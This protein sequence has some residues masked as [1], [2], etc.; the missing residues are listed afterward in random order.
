MGS[1]C[2][3]PGLMPHYCLI[4]LHEQSVSSISLPRKCYPPSAAFMERLCS[5]RRC[6]YTPFLPPQHRRCPPGL[7]TTSR[8]WSL[9]CL[10]DPPTDPLAVHPLPIHHI[11]FLPTRKPWSHCRCPLYGVQTTST[12]LG[13]K[14]LPNLEN[15]P[16]CS[17]ASYQYTTF[18]PCPSLP[19]PQAHHHCP[20]WLQVTSRRWGLEHLPPTHTRRD[21]LANTLLS[22][23]H[24]PFLPPHSPIHS[25][26][27]AA[28]SVGC[29][30]PRAAGGTE[31]S[32][33]RSGPTHVHMKIPHCRRNLSSVVFHPSL[34][35]AARSVGCRPP[36]GAGAWSAPTRHSAG[37]WREPD[38]L[39]K[40]GCCTGTCMQWVDAR[41]R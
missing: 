38:P 36:A 20:I 10:P 24:I 28:R 19:Y 8:R 33:A 40:P 25:L 16:T 3:F 37:V 39:Q 27:T 31:D 4:I 35:A 26:T 12:R 32:G 9:E 34:T 41:A 29:R 6:P 18:L 23:H 14:R 2:T 15:I 1:R 30:P 5:H 13:V 11:T 7:Q 17:A 22:I 21:L